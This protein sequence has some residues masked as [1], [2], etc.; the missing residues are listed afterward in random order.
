MAKI[1]FEGSALKKN[2]GK[3]V[4]DKKVNSLAVALLLTLWYC[5]YSIIKEDW[6]LREM[7]GRPQNIQFVRFKILV[8]IIQIVENIG[9]F[10]TDLIKV[11]S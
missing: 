8:Y 3:I 2:S 7:T 10:G 1:F 11:I 6:F 4:G 9:H 5:I